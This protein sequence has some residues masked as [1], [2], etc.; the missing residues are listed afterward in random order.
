MSTRDLQPKLDL[1]QTWA[2]R[3]QA[4]RRKRQVQDEQLEMQQEEAGN[5]YMN[6][7]EREATILIQYTSHSGS[8]EA[9]KPAITSTQG[10]RRAASRAV[11]VPRP[12][13]LVKEISCFLSLGAFLSCFSYWLL[14]L[15]G[16]GE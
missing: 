6:G 15:K 5:D 7:R 16:K 4:K 9:F 8:Y 1:G 3:N 14:L 13:S 10:R 11:H 2:K 12:L